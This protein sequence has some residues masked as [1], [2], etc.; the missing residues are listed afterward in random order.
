MVHETYYIDLTKF[1]HFFFFLS[2]INKQASEKVKRVRAVKKKEEKRTRENHHFPA[3]WELRNICFGFPCQPKLQKGRKA[4]IKR[5]SSY[6]Y[7]EKSASVAFAKTRKDFIIAPWRTALSGTAD[8]PTA[9]IVLISL[10]HVCSW[11]ALKLIWNM[12]LN[13]QHAVLNQ[14]EQKCFTKLPILNLTLQGL[15]PTLQYCVSLLQK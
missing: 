3:V 15:L 5:A 9:L 11:L 8:E 10:A 7:T 6:F 2:C 14:W 4:V 13:H 1:K 12:R